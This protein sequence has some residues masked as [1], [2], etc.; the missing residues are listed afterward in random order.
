MGATANSGSF[1]G[2]DTMADALEDSLA[3][4]EPSLLHEAG[5]MAMRGY[6]ENDEA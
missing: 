1:Y 4:N 5:H 6:P 3:T 2:G